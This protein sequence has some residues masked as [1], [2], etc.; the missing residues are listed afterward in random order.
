[1][2][3]FNVLSQQE[4]NNEESF[5]AEDDKGVIDIKKVPTSHMDKEEENTIVGSSGKEFSHLSI[6]N[7]D[8]IEDHRDEESFDDNDI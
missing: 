2:T 5:L 7:Q 8:T 4:N 1:V 6:K 3:D